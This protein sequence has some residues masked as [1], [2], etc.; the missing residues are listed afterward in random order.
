MKV[1]MCLCA[2]AS[3]I[4]TLAAYFQWI[5]T[6]IRHV[7][8]DVRSS[9]GARTAPGLDG[10]PPELIEFAGAPTAAS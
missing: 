2:I 10:F 8:A 7:R 1:V 3:S 9:A 5:E 4:M 6:P